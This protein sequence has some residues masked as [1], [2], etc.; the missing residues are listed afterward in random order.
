MVYIVLLTKRA[1]TAG[2]TSAPQSAKGNDRQRHARQGTGESGECQCL[3]I[4]ILIAGNQKNSVFLVKLSIVCSHIA[5]GGAQANAR[6]AGLP[7]DH[8]SLTCCWDDGR[9]QAGRVHQGCGAQG[10]QQRTRHCCC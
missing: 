8:V 6:L 5:S 1:A 10:M 4:A 7:Q 3:P 2:F 9:S